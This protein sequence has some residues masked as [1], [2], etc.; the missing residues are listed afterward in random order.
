MREV[1]LVEFAGD[2]GPVLVEVEDQR[3][4]PLPASAAGSE[5]RNAGRSFREAIA[6]I[7][8]IARAV[9]AQLE[10][11]APNEATVEFGIKLT[12]KTGIVLASTEAEGHFKL[13]LT[14]KKPD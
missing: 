3:V 11:L 10:T 8:P 4:G 2:S 12:G 9:M 6:G 7:E 13:S 1:V 5:I 14:W